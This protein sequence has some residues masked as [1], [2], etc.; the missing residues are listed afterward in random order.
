M[1]KKVSDDPKVEIFGRPVSGDE[2]CCEE[3][4]GRHFHWHNHHHH[5]G[6]GVLWGILFVWAGIVLL[7]NSLG[8]IPWTFWTYTRMFWPLILVLIGIRMVLGRNIISRLVV[9]ALSLIILG[10]VMIYVLDRMNSPLI[11]SVPPNVLHSVRSSIIIR[12]K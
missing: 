6:G 3:D 8:V 4:G 12:G 1:D 5:H 7:C 2:K 9:F 11:N 10:Y